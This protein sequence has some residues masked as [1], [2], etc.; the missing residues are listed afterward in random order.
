MSEIL[1]TTP[2]MEM[3]EQIDY[4][5]L[6]GNI[7]VS[8]QNAEYALQMI[9]GFLLFFVIVVLCYFCYKFF[10]IFF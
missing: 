2:V 3:A 7:L 1:E 4:T 5:E 9:A 10:R 8:S 6:L